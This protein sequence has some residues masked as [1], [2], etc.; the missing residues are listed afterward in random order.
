[1]LLR[2]AHAGCLAAMLI[3]AS[4]SLADFDDSLEPA[5]LSDDIGSVRAALDIGADPNEVFPVFETSAL[6]LAAIRGDA[7]IVTL[8]IEAGADVNWVGERGYSALSAAVRSC[9]A[10]W[11]VVETLL[12]AGADIDKRS[13][14]S[15]T[16]LMVAIQESRPTF[17]RRLLDRGADVDALNTHGE[18]ALN[19]AIYYRKPAHIALL[20]DRDVDPDP[21]RRLFGGFGA[22]YYPQFG[23]T[24]T[25]SADCAL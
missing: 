18:G 7:R 11:D 13:G 25:R 12:D 10:G 9:R 14:A 3:I 8:L 1:M 24:R 21:L 20:L 22:Y 5:I 15:L 16:P 23:E 17:F 4:G 6:M 19:Y 2:F